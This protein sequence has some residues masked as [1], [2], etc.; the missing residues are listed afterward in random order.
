[1][2]GIVVFSTADSREVA[3]RIARDLVESGEAACVNIVP[4]VRSVYRWQGKICDEGEWLLIIKSVRGKFEALRQ[5]IRDLHTY[6]LPEIVCI[7]IDNGD[8]DYL[9]WL[10]GA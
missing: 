7:E 8:P 10:S 3:D 4:G 5:R 6:E 2:E 1:M 9:R